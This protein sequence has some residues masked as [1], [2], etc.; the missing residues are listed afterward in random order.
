MNTLETKF[1][2]N[3]LKYWKNKTIELEREN[4]G[5]DHSEKISIYSQDALFSKYQ[6]KK[7]L[8]NYGEIKNNFAISLNEKEL[9]FLIKE[10]HSQSL[11]HSKIAK[12]IGMYAERQKLSYPEGCCLHASQNILLSNI[13]NG[14]P[15]PIL[16]M[17]DKPTHGYIGIFFELDSERGVL[18]LDPTSGQLKSFENG[19]TIPNNFVFVAK[20][21][22][23]YN[24]DWP[25]N[26]INNLYPDF[27][28]GINEI[29][30]SYYKDYLLFN[31]KIGNL[32][33]EVYSNTIPF[34]S[35]NF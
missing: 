19:E 5:I 2:A 21:K 18:I 9:I 35:L 33:D 20:P 10:M 24:A 4:E 6:I 32:I 1:H 31:S 28:L 12:K 14:N 34:S 7:L 30:K 27:H 22:F 17:K 8:R 29:S 26:K 25:N 16:L 15:S 3:N 13:N 23:D 11:A